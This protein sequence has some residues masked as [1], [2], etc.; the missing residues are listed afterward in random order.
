MKSKISLIILIVILFISILFFSSRFLLNYLILKNEENQ[1]ELLQDI[2]T[3][4]IT[5]LPYQ[6]ENIVFDD[7]C[8][9]NFITNESFNS[10]NISKIKVIEKKDKDSNVTVTV[11]RT[12]DRKTKNLILKAKIIENE[13]YYKYITDQRYKLKI[14]NRKL[15]YELGLGTSVQS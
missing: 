15:T 12:Y 1:I 4:F 2:Y 8:F 5:N 3:S 11:Y 13:N 10:E 14:K 7:S 6:E 9:K